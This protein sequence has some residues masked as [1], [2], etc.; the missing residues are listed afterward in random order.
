MNKTF[1][2][3]V[4]AFTLVAAPGLTTLAQE[5]NVTST[6]AGFD[7]NLVLTDEDVFD[8][9]GMTFDRLASFLR[10][11]GTLAEYRTPDIDGVPKT[12]AEIVWRVSNSYKINPKFLLA[13]L[14][15]EQSLVEDST[16]TQ[17]QFDW[18]TG[19][20]VC[21]SCSKD[22]PALTDFKG[23]ANQLEYAAKQMRER[24]YLRI[25]SDGQTRSGFAPGKTAMIDGVEV[26]PVNL[27]TA[28][29][30]TYTPHLN[31]NLNL[32]RIWKR[33]FTKNFPDGTLVRGQPS[34]QLWWIRFGLKRPFASKTVASTLVDMDKLVDAS[35]TELARYDLGEA[36]NFPN[37]ALLRDPSGRIWLISGNEKRHIKNMQAFREFGFN[38]DEVEEVADDDLKP[39]DNGR[40]I[41][42]EAK[43][44]QGMLLQDTKTKEVW[45][46]EAGERRLVKHA[47]LLSLYFKNRKPKKVTQTALN[48]LAIGE[49]YDLHDGE[50]V[51]SSRNSAVYVTEYGKLRPIPNADIFESLGWKWKN[52]VTLPTAVLDDYELGEA[53]LL[54]Q[55]PAQLAQAGR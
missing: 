5:I 47:S 3:F 28:S 49:P 2:A 35:D 21:D 1:F 4:L 54:D 34:G 7:P 51:K 18:A 11:K 30:Y 19:F 14:Q 15:K 17:R 25:L 41:T 42:L 12:A 39:Y 37:Y 26:T 43:Y 6:D 55:R 48:D 22:D 32:W 40:A 20:G 10:S 53:V 44:P 50:L 36:I 31:G 16:P 27:A 52:V 24:Y 38:M 23:F 8:V 13:L 46:A 45:Y 29:L 33:W 9:R